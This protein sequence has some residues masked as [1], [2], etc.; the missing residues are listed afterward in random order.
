MKLTTF[1]LAAMLSLQAAMASDPSGTLLFR[2]L[3]TG[4]GLPDNNVRNMTMLPDGLMCIQTSTMLNLYNGAD[5][6]S[7]R[8]NPMEIPYAEYSGLNNSFYDSKE[9]ILWCTSRDHIWIFNLNTREFEYDVSGRLEGFGLPD[10]E[11]KSFFLDMEGNYW[12][13]CPGGELY[14]CDRNTMKASHIGLFSDMEAPVIMEQSGDL[15]WMLSRNGILAGYDRKIGKFRSVASIFTTAS[16]SENSSRME[17]VATSEGD[18]WIMYDRELTYYDVSEKEMRRA[19]GVPLD[20]RDLYTSIA[21]DRNDNLWVGTARSGVS[22]IN[23]STMRTT[24]LPYLQQTNGKRIWH[25]TDISKIYA[26]RRGGIWIATL[27]EGLL[28]WHKDIYHLKTI[29]SSAPGCAIMRDEGVKCMVEDNGGNILVGTIKGLLRYNPQTGLMNM[30]YPELKD[31]LCISLYRDREGKIWLGTFYNGAF[32]ISEDGIR[33]YSWPETSAV[34]ISYYVGTPNFNCVRNFFED[35]KGNFWISVYGGVGLFDAETGQITLQRET[36]PE[37]ARFMMVRDICEQPDGSLL[38]S[39]DNGRYAYSPAED[40]V[41]TDSTSVN[42]HKQSNQAIVDARGLRWIA[43]SDGIAVTDLGTGKEYL[44]SSEEGLPDDNVLSIAADRTGNIWVSS[45]NSISRVMATAHDDG[46]YSFAVSTFGEQDGVTAGA[47]FQ[48]SIIAHSD[49]S[50]YFGGAH[51]IC[52]AVPE[53]LF[54][55]SYDMMPQISSLKIN[56]KA[57]DVGEKSN[58]RTILEKD[59]SRTER[60]VLKHNESFLTFSFSNLNYAN[61]THTSYR[62]MLENFDTGWN[63]IHSEGLGQATYTF[64]NPG[65][66]VFKVLAA[67]N[68]TDW[69]SRPAEIDVT[70]RPPLWKSTA[71][72]IFYAILAAGIIAASLQFMIQREKQKIR[73]RRE[74]EQR[75]QQ[76]ELDQ[77][78][79]RFF[80]NISHELRTPLSLILLPLESLMRDMKGSPEMPRLETM[81]HNARELLSLVNHLLDFR[82]LEMGGEKLNLLRGNIIEFTENILSQFRDAAARKGISMGMEADMESGTMMFDKDK[83]SKIINNILSNALKFT[84]SGGYIN[85]RISSG[86]TGFMRLEISDSGI[87]IPEADLAHIFD[88]FYQSD[89]AALTT[90]TGIGLSLVKQYAEMHGGKVSVSSEVN[91]GTT[92]CVEIPVEPA[93]CHASDISGAPDNGNA[94]AVPSVNESSGDRTHKAAGEED[95]G[96]KTVMVVDDNA[97]FRDYMKD[98]LG[99]HYNV[100]VASDGADCLKKLAETEPDVLVCDVMMP[101]MDGFEVT[102]RI[103]SNIETSHIPII[104]LT[105]RTSDDIRLEG[106]ETGADAYLTKPFKMDI[107]EARIR[108]LM[109]E[110]QRRISE[111]SRKVE[112]EPSEVTITTIDQKLMSRILESIE[113]NMDNA[114]YSVEE[115]SADVGMHRMNLYRKL[116]SLVGMTP[117][118]FIRSIRLKR[119]ARLLTEDPNLSVTE[120]SDMV[121]FNTPKYFS[122]YFR[123][124]FGC[125]PSQYRG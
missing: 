9:N 37:V 107:L 15:I 68:D 29:N 121:G 113:R 57:V 23:S 98:E 56:G 92:F 72:Y 43:T 22:I 89:N 2:M 93:A 12:V 16:R 125:N 94:G 108:N 21:I 49:G 102:R 33:H 61:P 24:T 110:K 123:E 59:I 90:G 80:T 75:R 50:I 30:P 17:M 95:S 91:K 70:I 77:M 106:Y 118:E 86:G 62:Y 67:D 76:E 69:S 40:K 97:D 45:F 78:K 47:F 87:G 109:E 65:E 71:A 35:S 58:G 79:F 13:M 32:C 85:V 39:G 11:I 116:Q 124:M 101:N 122:K 51:G 64:L 117:S 1:F 54:Q 120:V 96:R 31:E 105:A 66:Y 100:I 25:H 34:D 114:D 42:C 5:C 81:H 48:N 46:E 18:L 84:P 60:I 111:F 20:S 119:A 53:Q 3:D 63:E 14:V 41:F 73:F 74:Q 38:I 82:K 27:A 36:H 44:V 6:H 19:E 104:L 10:T 28:Y 103:K 7:Y 26:D 55:T 99:R 88:R 83:M 112:I 4:S 115:L 8:Y 52:K